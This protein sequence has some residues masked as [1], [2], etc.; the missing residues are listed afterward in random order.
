MVE[1]I[2]EV[3]RKSLLDKVSGIS[4]SGDSIKESTFDSYNARVEAYAS[5]CCY[6]ADC[7]DCDCG[8]YC[9]PSECV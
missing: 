9:I 7:G 3:S 4:L 2:L 5:D 1:K 8:G 6:G